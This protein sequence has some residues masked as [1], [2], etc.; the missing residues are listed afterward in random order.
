M[1]SSGPPS[2]PLSPPWGRFTLRADEPLDL[3]IGPQFIRLLL[4]EGEV[5]LAQEA[6]APEALGRWSRWAVPRS[7]GELGEVSVRL[8]PALPDRPLL[9]QPEVPFSLLPLAEARIFIRVPLTIR[10]EIDLE[11]TST[12]PPVLFRS[13]PTLAL[14]D[15]WW[16]EPNHGELCWWLETTARRRVEAS[17]LEPHLAICPLHMTNQSRADLRVEKLCFR[18]RYL[19]LFSDGQGF[20]ADTARVRYQGESEGSRINMTGTAPTEA[21]APRLV[22]APQVETQGFTARTFARLRALH[23]LGLGS[24][25]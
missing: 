4:T 5:R 2:L 1:A 12:R 22:A 17:L 24:P 11:P 14:S 23:P 7:G 8:R 10:L 18:M 3:R 9:V 20:W 15:T 21:T 16:G 6:A 13:I 25:P 19:S